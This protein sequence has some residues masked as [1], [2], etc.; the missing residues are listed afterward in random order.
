MKNAQFPLLTSHRLI[1]S[2]SSRIRSPPNQVHLSVV[3][4][5]HGLEAMCGDNIFSGCDVKGEQQRAQHQT[6]RNTAD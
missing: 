2:Q 5:Y 6:L 3:R 1:C 4:K